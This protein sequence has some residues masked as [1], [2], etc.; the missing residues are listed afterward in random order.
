MEKI[1][2]FF[3]SIISL[4]CSLFGISF[5]NTENQTEKTENGI[6]FVQNYRYGEAEREIMDYA[7]PE[8]ATGNVD[9]IIDVHGGAWIAGSKDSETSNVKACAQYGYIGVAINYTYISETSHCDTILDEITMALKAIKSIA[10][11]KGITVNKYIIEG[12]SA[13]GHLSAL[14]AYSRGAE[15]GITPAAVYDMC[16]PTALEYLPSMQSFLTGNTLG[17]TDYI[18]KL[19]SYLCGVTVTVDNLNTAEVKEALQK[20]SA[21]HYVD[22]AV[23]TILEHGM[24]DTIV[25]YQNSVILSGL[26]T[27]KGIR[28]DLVTLP[29]SNHDLGNDPEE[30]QRAGDLLIQYAADYLSAYK[31]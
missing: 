11:D 13:G 14:Y 20:V 12:M 5:G 10:A 26:L 4:I 15:S 21:T 31:G 8:G 30:A 29:N 2:A 1:I 28:N 7:Y 27:E 25:P 19:I 9:V 24:V 23:P 16:G 22:T 3:M 18:C 17:S 6:V